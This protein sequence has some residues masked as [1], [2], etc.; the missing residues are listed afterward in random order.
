MRLYSVVKDAYVFC[1]C[2]YKFDR[3]DVNNCVCRSMFWRVGEHI[4]HLLFSGSVYV[5]L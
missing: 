2:I 1:R 4:Y 5:C 3:K